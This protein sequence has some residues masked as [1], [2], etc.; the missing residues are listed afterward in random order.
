VD[1]D[2]LRALAAGKPPAPAR[3]VTLDAAGGDGELHASAGALAEAC[4][5]GCRT[6]LR[7]AN[8]G[9]RECTAGMLDRLGRCL[10]Q[11]GRKL[12]PDALA[13]PGTVTHPEEL[14][15]GAVSAC[16]GV[17]PVYVL[18]P[19]HA[20]DAIQRGGNL[21]LGGGAGAD[22]RQWW[23]GL[24]ALA[25]AAPS[26][27]LVPEAAGPGL[28]MLAPTQR[29]SGPSPGAGELIPA[30]PCRLRLPLDF[31]A[32]LDACGDDA[33]T[34]GRL[35][36]RVVVA[37]DELLVH[38]GAADGP[39]RLA[40]EID[41]IARAA[42]ARGRDPRSFAALNWLKARLGAFRDGARLASV[43]LARE[44][45]GVVPQ[46][47]P[48]AGVL[49]VAGARELDRALLIHG[50]RH[51]HLLSL[52]PW[53]LA[54]PETGRDCLA[55]LTALA[56]ADSVAWRRPDAECPAGLYSEALRFAWAVALRS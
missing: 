50:A 2:E 20:L 21:A 11:E 18:V 56:F 53:S 32:L 19:A 30:S 52:S 43:Q 3:V 1:R 54:P 51:T 26:V 25:M 29:W 55:L 39:R 35:A 42:I 37:A 46:P 13:L 41:G 16:E 15:L 22:A 4:D 47:F 48:L 33:D 9:G 17:P 27:S 5:A 34:L 24:V 45:G 31:G 44:R 12:A 36:G 40:L 8:P 49:E 28:S 6:T 23:R 10:Q 7:L 14:A 38:V